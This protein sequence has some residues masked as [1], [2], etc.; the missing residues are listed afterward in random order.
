MTPAK[1]TPNP[2]KLIGSTRFSKT[3]I[4]M[5]MMST[6]LRLPATVEVIADV[7]LISAKCTRLYA[8]AAVLPTARMAAAELGRSSR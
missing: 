8:K 7:T 2:T 4:E 5:M 6:I 1:K 3:M